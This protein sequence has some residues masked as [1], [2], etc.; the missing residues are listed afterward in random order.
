MLLGLKQREH[1]FSYVQTSAHNLHFYLYRATAGN[2]FQGTLNR[3][4]LVYIPLAKIRSKR[5]S[6]DVQELLCLFSLPSC[7]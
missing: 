6:K 4:I 2:S 5:T 1:S 3:K 7:F